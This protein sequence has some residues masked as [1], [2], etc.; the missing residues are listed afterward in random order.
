MSSLPKREESTIK[1]FYD[2]ELLKNALDHGPFITFKQK[3]NYGKFVEFRKF[4]PLTKG[5][6]D[7]QR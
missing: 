2:A 7:E 6:D 1:S 4:K 3:T 5:E